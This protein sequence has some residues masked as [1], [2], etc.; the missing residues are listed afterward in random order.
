MKGIHVQKVEHILNGYLGME[1][2]E[3]QHVLPGIIVKGYAPASPVVGDPA[4]VAGVVPLVNAPCLACARCAIQIGDGQ[5]AVFR[6]IAFRQQGLPQGVDF[7][8]AE[9]QSRRVLNDCRRMLALP[10]M[11]D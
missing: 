6:R 10:D 7:P 11:L 9:G 2:L 1:F 4:D 3:H 8:D 5:F